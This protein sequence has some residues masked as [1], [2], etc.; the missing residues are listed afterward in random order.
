MIVSP[1][2]VGAIA[3][4]SDAVLAD[5]VKSHPARFSTPEYREI[6]YAEITPQDVAGQVTV[7]D[8][9]IAEEYQ[10]A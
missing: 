5:Y 8:Q 6:E 9:M 4:P 3:P 10:G 1:D 2:S 7:S